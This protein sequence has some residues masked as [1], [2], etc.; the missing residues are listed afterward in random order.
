MSSSSKGKPKEKPGAAVIRSWRA[1]VHAKMRISSELRPLLADYNLTGPQWAVLRILEEAAP[2]GLRLSELSRRLRVTE[3]NVTGLVDRMVEGG[4]VMRDPHAEDRRVIIARLTVHGIEV[5]GRIAPL[6]VERL[7][8]L[9]G[10]LPPER[11]LALTEALEQLAKTMEPSDAACL[12]TECCAG[13]D[14]K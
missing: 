2:E 5:C 1:I 13:S 12:G 14:G 3:G 6:L 10:V 11:R 7:E 4:L 8:G 9:F